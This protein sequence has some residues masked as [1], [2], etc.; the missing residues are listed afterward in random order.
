MKICL[1]KT[2]SMG[3][4]LHTLPALTDAQRAMPNLEVDWVV[5]EN[6]V[7][8]PHWHNAVKQVIPIALRRWRKSPFST[9]TRNQWKTYRTLLQAAQYDAVIDAQGL[10]KS[11]FFATR[12]AHGCKHGYDRHSIREPIAAWFYDKH[13]AISYQQHAVERIRQLFAQSLGYPLPTTQGDY[14]IASHFQQQPLT[15]PYV[16]FFHGTTRTDK[17]LPDHQ[18]RELAEKLT[19]LGIQV[20]LPWSNPL[21]KQRADYIARGLPLVQILA[22]SSLSELAQHIVDAK[23]VIS[24]DTGLAHLTAALDKLNI[25][26]YGATDPKLIGAYGKNQ[27]YLVADSMANIHSDEIL[28]KLTALLAL[29]H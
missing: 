28:Q 22:K 17:F 14:A 11:A 23:A 21:E 25:T 4:I 20:C 9:T 5:E 16:L 24:V 1:I 12:L 7:E 3:D 8:I 15:T 2:S 19:A 6:F 18:W 10:F 27:H 29:P 26:L 13:Y